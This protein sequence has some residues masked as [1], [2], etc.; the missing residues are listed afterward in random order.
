MDLRNF[1]ESTRPAANKAGF[2]ER[3]YTRARY[4][5]LPPTDDKR[6]ERFEQYKDFALF[7]GVIA[8]VSYFQD[9]ISK[10]LEIDTE[11]AKNLI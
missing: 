9:S 11:A 8:G 4:W 10:L 5:L 3:T 6:T 7:L 2:F 1:K